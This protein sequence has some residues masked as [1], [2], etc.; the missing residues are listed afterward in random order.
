[1]KS[2]MEIAQ[3]LA[4]RYYALPPK[5]LQALASVIEPGREARKGEIILREGE[6]SRHLYHVESGLMRQFYYKKG[7]DVTEAFNSAGGHAICIM[8]TFLKQPTEL[9]IEALE[10]TVYHRVSIEGLKDLLPMSLPLNYLYLKILE[11][12]LIL[13]QRKADSWRFETARERYERFMR[14]YPEVARRASNNHVASY[15]LMT[16]QTLSKVRAGLL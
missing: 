5:D 9:M 16:P 15:L 12:D 2:P 11:S 8:S 14:E 13:S 4:T 1:M 3:D 6:V 10:P 7:R